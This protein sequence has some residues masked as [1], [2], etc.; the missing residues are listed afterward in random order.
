MNTVV[1]KIG[2]SEG[3]ILPKEMLERLGVSA[4]DRLDIVETRDGLQLVRPDTDFAKQ[5]RAA[6]EGMKKYH[7]ALRELAK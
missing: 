5:M 2:N 6:H 4:G 7:D 1:R 3:V